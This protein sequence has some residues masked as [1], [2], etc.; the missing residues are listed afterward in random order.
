MQIDKRALVKTNNDQINENRSLIPLGA[1][2][3][4]SKISF[5]SF[6]LGES[7]EPL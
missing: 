6:L 7:L 4:S 5:C 3:P 1:K 2:V